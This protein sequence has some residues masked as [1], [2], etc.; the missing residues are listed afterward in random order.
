MSI[1]DAMRDPLT[2]ATELTDRAAEAGLSDVGLEFVDGYL[3]QGDAHLAIDHI[4]KSAAKRGF[5]LPRT[6]LDEV[7]ELYSDGVLPRESTEE[8]MAALA[9]LIPKAA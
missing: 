8:T 5:R 4:L 3:D 7:S 1:I 2:I 9:V 6:L